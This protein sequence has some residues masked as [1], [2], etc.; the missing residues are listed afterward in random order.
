MN[1]SIEHDTYDQDALLAGSNQLPITRTVTLI[2]GQNLARG[3][4]LGKITASGKY[5][6][7]AS[8]AGD[9]SNTPTAILVDATD[10]SGGDKLCGIYEAGEFNEAALTL[11]V[12]H[13]LASIRDGLRDLGIHLKSIVA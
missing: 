5:T 2:S 9:G 4:V 11:G 13:T 8:A 1:P 7:S 6:L 10:A 12:G 3:A